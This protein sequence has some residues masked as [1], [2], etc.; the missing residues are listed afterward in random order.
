M[1]S[2][3]NGIRTLFVSVK[4]IQWDADHPSEIE[5]LSKNLGFELIVDRDI[6]D[7]ELDELIS[8]SITDQ[9]GFCHKGF[10]IVDIRNLV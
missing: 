10:E 4:N 5:H 8:D 7:E 2:A 9:T 1:A 6:E 3:N